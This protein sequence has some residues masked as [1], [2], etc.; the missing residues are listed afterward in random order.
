MWG[1]KTFQQRGQRQEGAAPDSV[2][3]AP[4]PAP[5]TG[6]RRDPEGLTRLH[7]PQIT[8]ENLTRRVWRFGIDGRPPHAW[9]VRLLPDG[10]LAGALGGA[11]RRWRIDNGRLIFLTD[12]DR[13]STVFDRVYENRKGRLVLLGEFQAPGAGGHVL[14]E[15]DPLGLAPAGEGV[16]LVWRRRGPP[17]RNLII[18]RADEHSLHQDWLR[19]IDDADR[20]WDLCVSY[21]GREEN[22]VADEWSEYFALQNRVH[23]FGALFELL[24]EGSPLWV[25][26]HFALV[27]GDLVASWRDWNAL[28]ATCRDYRLDLAQPSLS[29][30]GFVGHPITRRDDR[31]VLRYVSFVQGMAPIFSRRALRVCAPT[32]DVVGGLGLDVAWPQLLGSPLNRIAV[33]DQTPVL[34]VQPALGGVSFTV[35]DG[36]EEGER[37]RKAYDVS[38]AEMVEYGGIFSE[39]VNRQHAW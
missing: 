23:K 32:F 35:R 13:P 34:H 3:S 15:A 1:F 11:D 16:E 29:H 24:H 28:F 31:F 22:F 19:D 20:S 7:S 6:A 39:A 27:D 33:I 26:D 14:H 4:E 30:D 10:R 37:L 38:A 17:R 36:V 8:A 12:D 18:V 9:H 21:Y 25:Y 5:T 2:E